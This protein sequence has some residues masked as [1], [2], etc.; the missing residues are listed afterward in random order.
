[1][2]RFLLA[3]A[4][5]L[6]CAQ[7]HDLYLMPAQWTPA[8]GSK[9]EVFFENGDGFPQGQSSVKP[10]RLRDTRVVSGSGGSELT[11]ITALEKRSR[12][13]AQMP[14]GNATV[15]LTSRTIPNHID[16]DAAKFTEYL[17]HE[18]LT[19]IVAWRDQHGEAGRAGSEQYSKYVKSIVRVGSGDNGW[20]KETGLTIEFIPEADPYALKPGDQLPVRVLLRGRPAVD[21]P[22]E[23]AWLEQG[24]AK[25]ETVGRTNPE[26]RASIPIRAR[27]PHRLHT[28]HIERCSD[29]K[30]ADW[31]SFW[32]SLTFAVQ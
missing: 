14:A 30:A 16:L 5:A 10:E 24:V 8:P 1:M 22:V 18:E 2:N 32:A 19:P 23:V 15:V 12:A 17:K 20:R 26:G 7:A 11:G 29:P 3:L 6:L 21:V 13:E 28:I 9:I 4:A 27:G 31:E 25:L